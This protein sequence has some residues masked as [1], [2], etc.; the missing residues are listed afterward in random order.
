MKRNDFK[1][2]IYK[3]LEAETPELQQKLI[4]ILWK[5][6]KQSKTICVKDKTYLDE[7]KKVD[8]LDEL[9][10]IIKYS[11]TL[12]DVIEKS[13]HLDNETKQNI[14]NLK[15]NVY[16][17]C[18]QEITKELKQQKKDGK[19][20]LSSDDIDNIINEIIKEEL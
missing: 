17:I 8:I 14:I 13:N 3:I 16:N 2:E 7:V 18:D 11:K 4:N 9:F 12:Y 10:R 6:V 15:E 19:E 5:S 1:Q 20:F